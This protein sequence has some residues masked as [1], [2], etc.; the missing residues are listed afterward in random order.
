MKKDT[1]TAAL[2]A[3]AGALLIKNKGGVIS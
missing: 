1:G 3:V 2:M